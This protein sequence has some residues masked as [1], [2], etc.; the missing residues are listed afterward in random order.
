MRGAKEGQSEG[1]IK[2]QLPFRARACLHI[3]FGDLGSQI[4]EL[5]N[6]NGLI[7]LKYGLS[8]GR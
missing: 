8:D 3:V 6:C 5:N 1:K 2:A 7:L 4:Q